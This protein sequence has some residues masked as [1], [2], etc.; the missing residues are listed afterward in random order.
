MLF[1][2][3]EWGAGTPFQYFTDHR[4]PRARAG[5]SREGRR[6]EFAAFGWDPADVPDP[7]A[8]ETFASARLDWDEPR[9]GAHADLLAWYRALIAVRRCLAPA[10][11]EAPVTVT[12]DEAA[13]W[14]AI[15]RGAMRVLCN[16][17][18][19]ERELVLEREARVLLASAE[20]HRSPGAVRL[21]G[22]SVV[23]A[24]ATS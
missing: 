2:G 5:P 6:R 19:E 21:P 20:V 17:A 11:G 14:L 7:Q 24:V 4:G 22:E 12:Y 1:Q 23:V 15:R 9:R 3:E 8:P 13:Q 16:L 18:G 10:A